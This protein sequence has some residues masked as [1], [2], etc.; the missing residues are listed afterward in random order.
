MDDARL[1]L[2]RVSGTSVTDLPLAETGVS[3]I[4]LGPGAEPGTSRIVYTRSSRDTDIF[5]ASIGDRQRGAT[6][7]RATVFRPPTPKARPPTRTRSKKRL[8][9]L[10]PVPSLTLNL[11]ASRPVQVLPPSS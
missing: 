11:R 1:K 7:N 10:S 2:V 3:A 4:D 5:R 9:I 8:S 6:P